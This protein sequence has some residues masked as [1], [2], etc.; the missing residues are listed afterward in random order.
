MTKRP[1]KRKI[2]LYFRRLTS[3][4]FEGVFPSS[5]SGPRG[6]ELDEIR[7]YQ[8]G[9]SLR[10]IDWKTTVRARKL[11]IRVSLP[12]RRTSVLFLIDKSGS[13]R[14]GASKALKEDVLFSALSILIEAVGETGNP[15]GLATFTDRIER[16]FPPYMNQ[17]HV[18]RLIGTLKREEPH[19]TLTDLDTVFFYVN[20]LNLPPSVVFIL[21]DF[22]AEDNYYASLSTLSKRHEVIPIVVKDEREDELPRAR[23]FL[24]VRD[25]ES[26]ELDLL[27]LSQPLLMEERYLEHFIR[28]GLD[29]IVVK[30]GEDEET[31]RDKFADFFEKRARTRRAVRR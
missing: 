20:G 31:W 11:H 13:K 5:V 8:P 26:R 17:K 16:Y 4:L 6:M 12:E 29:Y 3:G 28:L 9:D 14:F 25:M 19:G 27:D 18:L 22:I 2:Q 24:A 23:A 10:S 15:I 30:T 1:V 21:S 7:E